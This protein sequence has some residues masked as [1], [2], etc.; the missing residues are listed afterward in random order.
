MLQ[1]RLTTAGLVAD[2]IDETLERALTELKT[3]AQT[4][5]SDETKGEL[6]HQI[7]D[8]EDTYSLLSIYIG[9]I[10]LLSEEGQIIWS[11]SEADEAM[12]INI[13]SYPSLSQTIRKDEASISGLI[14]APA[15]E[16][17]KDLVL[18][19]VKLGGAE[20]TRTPDPLRAKEVLSQL[21]YS[22]RMYLEL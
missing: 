20:E 13:S 22:P 15:N 9:G 4:V 3:T 18:P 12:A 2:Y 17:K 8:L 14:S 1:D 19:T 11:Q 21:S 10:Y 16:R 7:G 6:E 5:E